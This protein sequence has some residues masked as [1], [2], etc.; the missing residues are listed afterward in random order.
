MLTVSTKL[1]RSALILALWLLVVDA[2]SGDLVYLE[3]SQAQ[4]LKDWTS[5]DWSEDPCDY[6]PFVG[7]NNDGMIDTLYLRSFRTES[8]PGS[9]SAL[10]KLQ[11]IRIIGSTIPGT[12]PSELGSITSL[13]SVEL[14]YIEGLSGPILPA[15]LNSPRIDRLILNR[16]NFNGTIPSG[17]DSFASLEY[18]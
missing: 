18:L 17:I 3:E 1:R 15:L 11:I 6:I 14:S 4:F 9:I 13:M 5:Q 8:I 7:C 10:Q 16:C 2:Q 12:I